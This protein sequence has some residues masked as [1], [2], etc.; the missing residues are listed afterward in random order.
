M[1]IAKLFRLNQREGDYRILCLYTILCTIEVTCLRLKLYSIYILIL[2]IVSRQKVHQDAEN[3][4]R[5]E[6]FQVLSQ[7]DFMPPKS[8]TFNIDLSFSIL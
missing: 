5:M 6:S 7:V 2:H 3:I 4:S 8:V 1:A